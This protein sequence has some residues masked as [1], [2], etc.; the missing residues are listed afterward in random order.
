VAANVVA[1]PPQPQSDTTHRLNHKK[2]HV[3]QSALAVDEV[4]NEQ[5]LTMARTRGD[6][7]EYSIGDELHPTPADPNRPRHKHYYLHYRNPINHRDARFCQLFDMTGAGGRVLH[8]HIQGVGHSKAD[9]TKVIYYT[10]KDKLYIASP[11]L[12]NYD[13]ESEETGPAWAIAMNH[14]RTVE[15]GMHT[16]MHRY[17][18]VF[19]SSAGRVRDALELRLG[20]TEP[21]RFTLASF[22]IPPIAPAMLAS[23]ALV[24]QGAPAIGK[25]QF[26]LAHFKR[27]LLVTRMD[28]LKY[29]SLSTD[30]LV[31]DQMRFTHP[32][33]R[34]KLNLTADELINLLDKEVSRSIGA[35]YRDAR[36]PRDMPRLFTTNRRVLAGEPIFPSGTP[37]END[38]ISSRIEVSRWLDTDLRSNPGAN[39]RRA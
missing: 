20:R 37:A 6:L 14:A 16:L 22:T 36:I 31:F 11:N 15:E 32:E 35:R 1:A 2:L 10:Q 39:A 8:P 23:K 29:I 33:D 34:A 30:G 13:E 24:L 7:I 5:V 3:T 21:A 17:P 25:T 28:D 19:Y 27:P 12:L 26:A 4:S 18:G 9:R 38:A